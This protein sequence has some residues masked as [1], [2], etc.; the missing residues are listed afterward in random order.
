[1]NDCKPRLDAQGDRQFE[2][3]GPIDDEAPQAPVTGG[4]DAR[5]EPISKEDSTAIS[6][7][8]SASAWRGYVV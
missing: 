4:L 3:E 2:G 7:S 5:D 8:G 6:A 1:M